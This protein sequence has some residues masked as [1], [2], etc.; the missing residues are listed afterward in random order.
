MQESREVVASVEVFEDAGQDLGLL[1]G[2]ID[3]I[4]G[5]VVR[6][7]GGSTGTGAHGGEIRG[8]ADDVPV[9]GEETLLGS[10]AEGD[11]RRGEGAIALRFS[12]VKS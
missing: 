10:Y 7:R 9:S 4:V 5:G 6:I 8:D 1:V 2:E 12:W 3:G 11:C